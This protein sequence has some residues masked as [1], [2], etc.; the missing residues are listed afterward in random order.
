M[1]R[2]LTRIRDLD[3]ASALVHASEGLARATAAIEIVNRRW[4]LPSSDGQPHLKENRNYARDGRYQNAS[5]SERINRLNAGRADMSERLVGPMNAASTLGRAIES[6]KTVS[7]IRAARGAAP[8]LIE[9][10][11][12]A[13][14]IAEDFEAKGTSNLHADL[15]ANLN[16]ASSV[17][18]ISRIRN[19]HA[20]ELAHLSSKPTDDNARRE[21][22]I[23]SSP[24]VVI[25]ATAAGS[26][27][28]HDVIEALRAHREELFD[29]LKRESTRRER[30]QF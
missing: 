8:V 15:R 11:G 30:A 25:N 18:A 21:I 12:R 5:S 2:I 16:V 4:L 23:N 10:A 24:T 29:Q 7:A 22:T 19:V 1:A 9:N 13:S 20:R 14:R 26:N 27:V 28:R 6:G 3:R 17:R